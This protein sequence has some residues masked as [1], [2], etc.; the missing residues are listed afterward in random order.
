MPW[1]PVQLESGSAVSSIEEFIAGLPKA[2]LHLHLEGTVDS[3]TLW[4]LAERYRTPLHAGREALADVYR[5]GDFTAFLQAFKTVCEHLRDA[6]D[7]ALITY[8]ALRRLAE[9]NVRYAEVSLSAGV[10]LRKQQDL[11]SCL[12]GVEAGYRRGA[13]GG[14]GELEG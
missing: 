8:N 11:R 14:G 1:L 10:I 3:A 9:Q 12:E 7:Y 6:D 2:E 13:G 5:T 4:Q